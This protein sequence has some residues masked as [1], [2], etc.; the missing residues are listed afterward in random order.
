MKTAEIFIVRSVKA[1]V[2]ALQ[3]WK[4]APSGKELTGSK[5]LTLL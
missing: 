1:S 4:S 5:D 2:T 3:G